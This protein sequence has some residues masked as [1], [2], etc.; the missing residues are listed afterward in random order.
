MT[1][2]TRK[3]KRRKRGRFSFELQGNRFHIFP[4][5][6]PPPSPLTDEQI[7]N[8]K[9]IIIN[10]SDKTPI[11]TADKEMESEV[12]LTIDPTSAIHLIRTAWGLSISFSAAFMGTLRLLAP[13]NVAR[14]SIRVLGDLSYDYMMGRY[15]RTTYTKLNHL[16]SRHY[17]FP[18]V[19]RALGRVAVQILLMT[20]VSRVLCVS[21]MQH[22]PDDPKSWWTPILWAG[23]ML[24]TGHVFSKV[25]GHD[26]S[27]GLFCCTYSCVTN[28][29]C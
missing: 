27:F 3:R 24:G 23:A 18:A 13:L 15:V 6:P 29:L 21:I 20:I 26:G 19:F 10:H 2:T 22:P 12:S 25:V 9:T 28:L 14:R 11:L 17:D 1:A 7:L 4:K 16:Y 8:N 5:P